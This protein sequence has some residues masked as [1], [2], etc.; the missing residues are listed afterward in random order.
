[1]NP[2]PLPLVDGDTLLIDNSSLE[3]FTT[4][5][6][7]AYYSIVR[8]LKPSGE[9]SALVFGGIIHKILETR[10]RAC[11]SL[12]AQSDQVTNLMLAVAEREFAKWTPPEDDFR[13]YSCAVEFIRRYE[14][15][16]PFEQFE[17]LRGQ[18]G[19]PMIE[20]PF[21]IPLGEIEWLDKMVKVIWMGKIDLVYI[22]QNGG[23]LY[24]MDHKTTSIM[25]PNFAVPFEISHQLY[26]YAWAVEQLTG[27]QVSA[28]VVNGLGM[29]KPTK[30]GKAFEFMRP[31]IPVQRLLVDEWK[32]DTMH[33]VS[34]FLENCRRGYAPK[35]TVWCVGKF[36]ECPFRKV[37]TLPDPAQREVML[38][39]GEFTSNTWSPLN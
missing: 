39:S 21:A 4:C 5:P 28:V 38:E 15:Q 35:H 24:V 18:D 14:E 20:V 32:L 7:Q 10:Y 16:Y 8:K 1:M 12:H 22:S 13:T 23:G 34:D 30:T 6:R 3:H 9:R 33:I 25:G 31:V 19:S 11:T 37:C 36:G 17:V 2:F 27:Q 29:R 26:G